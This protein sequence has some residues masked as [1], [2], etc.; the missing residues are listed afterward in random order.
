MP[1]HMKT[2]IYS[3]AL[4]HSWHLAWKHKWLWPLGLFATFLGQMGILELLTVTGTVSGSITPSQFI[5][6]LV[7]VLRG[8]SFS[9]FRSLPVNEWVSFMWI[10]GIFVG[11][12][13]FV[14]YIATVSQGALIHITARSMG[15]NNKDIKLPTVDKSWHAGIKHFWRLFF[16]NIVKKLILVAFAIVLAFFSINSEV[17]GTLPEIF[18]FL[19]VLFSTIILGFVISFL[20]I[21][22]ACF[23]VLKEQGFFEA[24]QS[25]WKL[26]TDHWLVSIEVGLIL[27]A[28][29]LFLGLVVGFSMF[30]FFIPSLF[31]WII[32]AVLGSS[33]LF[34]TATTVAFLL[35]AIFII[36]IGSVFTVFSIS[37]WTYLFTHMHKKGIK[38]KVHHWLGL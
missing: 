12:I 7:Q 35:F 3:Q 19:G 30:F 13:V 22:A 25:A 27:I 8:V 36:L 33:T 23:V 4:R 31:L 2:P 20:V 17:G 29:N 16:I 9:V 15:K 21:Y 34:A 18:R 6:E 28:I 1:V 38:S 14:A 32:A 24:L 26:F 10:I 37:T 11:V 5:F